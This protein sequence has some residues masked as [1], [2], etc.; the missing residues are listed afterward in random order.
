MIGRI[1]ADWLGKEFDGNLRRIKSGFHK[2]ENYKSLNG[3]LR[4]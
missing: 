1:G 3:A 4:D 2:I